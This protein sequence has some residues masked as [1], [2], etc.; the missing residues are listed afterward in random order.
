MICTNCHGQVQLALTEMSK[1]G[2]SRIKLMPRDCRNKIDGEECTERFFKK[3][4][5]RFVVKKERY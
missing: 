2:L 5:E 1:A 3:Y 4:Y